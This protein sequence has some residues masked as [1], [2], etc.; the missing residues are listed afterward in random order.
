M[1]Y[2]PVRRYP[3]INSTEVS[4]MTFPLDLHVLGTPPAFILSQDQ[5]LNVFVFNAETFK[6]PPPQIKFELTLLKRFAFAFDICHPKAAPK[7]FFPQTYIPFFSCLRNYCF[8]IVQRINLTILQIASC[9]ICLEKNL[10]LSLT[11]FLHYDVFKVL[12]AFRPTRSF[13]A[14][15][16][17]I[18][19]GG[20]NVNK[21][22]HNSDIISEKFSRPKTARLAS[23]A[24]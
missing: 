5:T 22:F 1:C 17:I 11:Q 18:G 6:T 3:V 21:I 14:C 24:K 15:L 19:K 16:I 20:P 13:V 12:R 10:I 2:S 4:F 7:G 23:P 9:I 8:G